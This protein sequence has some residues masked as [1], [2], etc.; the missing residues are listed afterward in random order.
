MS[1]LVCGHSESIEILQDIQIILKASRNFETC[2]KNNALS[3]NFEKIYSI[4]FC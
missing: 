3:R 4:F 2:L 1:L